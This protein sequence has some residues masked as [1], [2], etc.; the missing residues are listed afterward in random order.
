MNN[1]DLLTP[2]QAAQYLG[3]STATLAIWRCKKRY[4]LPYVKIG[5]L[6]R[7]RKPELDAFIASRAVCA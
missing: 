2:E 4:P 1:P 5:G 3:V 7:Y 6:V